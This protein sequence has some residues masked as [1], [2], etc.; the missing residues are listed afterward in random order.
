MSVPPQTS[1]SFKK[2]TGLRNRLLKAT[3][4]LC[5]YNFV[6]R[7]MEVN[8]KAFAEESHQILRKQQISLE[9]LRSD[10]E[11][12]KTELAMEARSHGRPTNAVGQ[13]KEALKL[14]DELEHLNELI[15][16]EK[17]TVQVT[18]EQAELLQQKIIHTR[19]NMGGVNAA[20]ENQTMI[21]KQVRILENRLDKALVKFNE[22][23]AHNKKL[24]DEID[25]L[26][27]ER[28]VFDSVYKKLEKA[29]PPLSVVS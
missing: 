1:P 13:R 6:V 8:R 7:L 3:P 18:S 14:R 21:A 5:S 15:E 2:S 23:L 29:W 22:S 25:D 28:V 16:Q 12:L 24:R 4:T 20:K 9:K 19:K 27:R 17:Q 26:R 11:A 10:N